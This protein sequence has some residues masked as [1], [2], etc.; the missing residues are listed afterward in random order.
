M[1]AQSWEVI[2]CN[3]PALPFTFTLDGLFAQAD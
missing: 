3:L 2:A 1:T